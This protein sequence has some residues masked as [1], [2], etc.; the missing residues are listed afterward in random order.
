MPH[1]VQLRGPSRP[2]ARPDRDAH[3]GIA[4]QFRQHSEAKAEVD[5]GYRGLT[6]EFPEQVDAPPKKPKDDAPLG[7]HI[8]SRERHR[9]QSSARIHVEH[10]NAEYQQWRPPQRFTGR[11]ETNPQTHLAIA[12]IVS[13]RSAKRVPR[14]RTSTALVLVRPAAC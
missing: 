2:H 9:R 8:A 13:D 5:E 1:S 12:G 3:E 11:R 14:R 10:T 7:E 6:N 4:E